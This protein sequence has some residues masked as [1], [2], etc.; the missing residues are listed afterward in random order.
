M[1]RRPELKDTYFDW[2]TSL[3][4]PNVSERGRYSNLLASLEDNVF[5]F[6][7]PLDENRYIDGMALRNRFAYENGINES[8]ALQEFDNKKC[9]MLEMLVAL[10]LRIEEQ[11][12]EDADMGNRIST[13]FFE[14]IKTLRLYHMT[15]D[16]FDPGWVKY[17]IDSLLN[18]KYESN[19]DGGLFR[20]DK[21]RQDLRSVEIWYQMVWYLDSIMK[22]ER[23]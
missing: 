17:R 20:V 4:I 12:M 5:Y 18:H 23:R 6:T 22:G 21:P 8:Y 10:S 11:I 19:G 1:R 3:V 13:W 16:N 7:I 2:M 15:D 14:M 9:S